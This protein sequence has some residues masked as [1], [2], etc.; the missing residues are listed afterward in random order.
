MATSSAPLQFSILSR[1]GVPPASR[2]RPRMPSQIRAVALDYDGTL[3]TD[4]G[5]TPAVLDA[6]AETRARGLRVVLVTG[7]ILSELRAVFSDA[8]DRF[9]AVVAENGAVIGVGRR[10]RALAPPVDDALDEALGARAWIVM[11]RAIAAS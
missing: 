6:I 7:R 5:P 9:D 3:A 10:E 4:C 2:Y 11:S 1:D 8:L